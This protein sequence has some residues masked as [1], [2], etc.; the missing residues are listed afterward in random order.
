MQ[1][2]KAAHA[3]VTVDRPQRLVKYLEQCLA[4]ITHDYKPTRQAT[5]AS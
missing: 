1:I 5:N 2:E 3:T 4:W